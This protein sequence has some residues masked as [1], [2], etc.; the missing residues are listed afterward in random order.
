MISVDLIEFRLP[1]KYILVFIAAISCF[2][3]ISSI[4]VSALLLESQTIR[5]FGNIAII[6]PLHIDGRYIK[7]EF[8]NI[9]VL[10]GVLKHGFEDDPEGRWTDS[11]GQGYFNQFVDS[12]VRDNFRAIRNWGGNEIRVVERAQYW[13]DNTVGNTGKAHRDVIKRLIEIAGEEGLYVNF[14]LFSLDTA[15]GWHNLPWG[16]STFPTLDDFKDFWVDVATELSPYPNVMF[17]LFNEVVS[18][19]DGWFNG[20]NETIQAIRGVSDTIIIVQW[21]WDVWARYGEFAYNCTM[22]WAT[23]PRIQ[24]TNILFSTH[25][26]QDARG[27]YREGGVNTYLWNYTDVK[28]AFQD[29]LVQW[30]VETAN[31]P[32]YIGEYGTFAAIPEPPYFLE[33][34]ENGLRILNEWG[35]SFNAMWWWPS[36]APAG[37]YALYSS[38][39]FQPTVWG[40]IVQMALMYSP[41]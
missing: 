37:D 4:F 19:Q 22:S 13:Q 8:G 40:E 21:D 7:D 27:I 28:K 36:N 23:D 25:M 29:E 14:A 41:P 34:A 26:Y 15:V 38:P 1:K 3:L 16:T 35:I 33:S 20:V 6:S 12:V 32:L 17:E 11:G 18:D 10:R 30:F 39:N 2:V 24:G 5:N 9:V 31:K